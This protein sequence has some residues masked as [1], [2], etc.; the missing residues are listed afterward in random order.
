MSKRGNYKLNHSRD[1]STSYKVD[2]YFYDIERSR[3]T[4]K[5]IKFYQKL[6]YIF[7][8]NG[9]DINEECDKRKIPHS[10]IQNP[11]GRCGYSE[12][13]DKMI[14]ILSEKGLYTQKNDNR[15]KFETT[16]NIVIDH[17]GAVTRSYQ[18]IEYKGDNNANSGESECSDL[19]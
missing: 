2:N 12:A 4:S 7:K 1:L 18:K 9:L 3:A 15:K 6:W 19:S 17:G 13:I 16:Y 11:S 8:N 5:Q 10:I 14:N